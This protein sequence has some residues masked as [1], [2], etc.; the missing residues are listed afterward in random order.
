M[1]YLDS[2]SGS[3][4]KLFE[5]NNTI[6]LKKFY[7]SLNIREVQSFQKQKN[8]EGY[9]LGK[10]KILSAE[11]SKIEK[12]KK[13]IV[14]KYYNGL[15][16][17]ELMLKGDVYTHNVLNSFLKNY[18]NNLLINSE[19]KKF[20]KEIYLKKC[21]QIKRK[22]Q[23]KHRY[24]FKKISK[25]IYSKLE[26]IKYNINGKCHGDLTLSNIIINLETKEIIL[27]DFLKTYKD[28]PLQDICKLI[29][30]IR[31]Y[32]SARKFGENDLL[33]AKSFCNNLNPFSSI[34][35]NSYYKLLELEMLMTLLRILPYVPVEDNDTIKWLES[36]YEKITYN[37]IKN[38]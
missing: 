31:L 10:F 20:D 9:Y 32:W 33:R 14:L 28:Y 34:K 3:K 6:Y 26:G 19:I 35:K 11:I 8:F 5:N 2:F 37:F 18:I 27:I 7:R 22:T 30:D 1:N 29:Q 23:L 24:I 21:N 17:S 16:G 36:S 38:I 13:F 12:K 15:A 4:F 25:N